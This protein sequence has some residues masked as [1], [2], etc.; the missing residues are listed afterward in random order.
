MVV[1][2]SNWVHVNSDIQ[3]KT[4]YTLLI[5]QSALINKQSAV[6]L[7]TDD[8]IMYRMIQTIQDQI[9][10]LNDLDKVMEWTDKWG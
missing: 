4:V 5:C 7:F 6:H 10:L 3:Q 8:C 1:E 9:D 2:R